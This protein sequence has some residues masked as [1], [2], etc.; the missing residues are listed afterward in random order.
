[1]AHR[2]VLWLDAVDQGGLIR[3]GELT[4]KELVDLSIEAIAQHNPALNAIVYERFDRAREEAAALGDGGGPLAGVP[5]VVKDLRLRMAGD[6]AYA[7]STALRD[8]GVRAGA[9]DA[10]A[11]RMRRAGLVVVGRGASSEFGVGV[12]TASRAFGITRNPWGERLS[13]G[14]SSGGSAVSVA[15]GFVAMAHGEDLGGSIRN[16]AAACGIV[17]LKPSRGLVG[18]GPTHGS[19][20]GGMWTSGPMAR[21]VR[22]VAALLDVMSGADTFL[23]GLD[24]GDARPLRVGLCS[25]GFD[26]EI[27]VDPRCTE[28]V[29][30]AGRLLAQAGHHVEHGF[31]AQLKAIKAFHGQVMPVLAGGL[32]AEL[33]TVEKEL[34]RAIEPG[35]LEPTSAMFRQRAGVMSA[36]ELACALD[37]LET[38]GHHVLGWW[39]DGHDLLVTPTVP[40]AAVPL[41]WFAEPRSAMDRTIDQLHFTAVFNA[42]GQP[43]LS[44]PLGVTDA[45][46]PVGVQLVAAPGR[47]ALLLRVAAQLERALPWRERIP[48]VHA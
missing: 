4:A 5:M 38:F 30:L 39:A 13:P 15:A 25:G 27:A 19:G 34:G 41:D 21:S 33:A 1:M 22:D 42:T 44:L 31:P 12:S 26:D 23:D 10:L 8:A 37:W 3:S 16:P 14:G 9:D 45:G 47:D 48:A 7:G 35:E 28:T 46:H 18:T 43:A 40:R 36:T 32:A 6:P 20:P 29:E 24:A 17:G 2:D 11:A